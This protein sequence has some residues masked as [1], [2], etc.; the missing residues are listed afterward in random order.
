IGC[1]GVKRTTGQHPGGMVVVPNTYEVEDFTPVQRP[2]DD[3]TK[4]IITT[5]FDFNSMHD[6]LLK[7]DEL[8]HDVPTIYKH[9]TDLT[10]IDVLDIDISDRKLY[11]LCTSPEPLGVTEEELGWPTG[12]LSI[13]EMGTDFTKGM[14]L[15][16][17]PQTFADLIQIAGLSHGTAVWLGNAQDLIKD[18]TCTISEVIG[19]R[20]SIMVYLMHCGLEPKQAFDIMETVRKKNKYLTPEMIE[21][22]KSHNVPAWYIESCDKI[23]YMFPKAHAAAYIIASLRLAWFKIYKPLEYYCAYLTVRGDDVDA[24]AMSKGKNAVKTLLQMIRAKGK[25]ASAAE[26]SKET[27]MM[28][29]YEAMVRGIEFLPIDIYKSSAGSYEPEDGKIRMPFAAL[30]GVGEAAAVQLS[31]AR[32][33]GGAEFSSIEDFAIRAGAGK[34]TVE[35]LKSCGAFGD[36]PD[37]DQMSLF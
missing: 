2:A 3:A 25:E 17:R 18:G 36:L 11:E 34:S 32:D 7:L 33:D 8:G 5:H 37:S 12:T 28:I 27:I 24:E 6:T 26:K 21:I 15:E 16:A 1:T 9:L 4:D 10:G 29:V 13:P 19:T 20:D 23:Q 30:A 35:L 31:K 22:M 14:L